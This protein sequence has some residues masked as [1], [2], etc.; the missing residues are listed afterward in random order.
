MSFQSLKLL[1]ENLFPGSPQESPGRS[2]EPTWPLE[3]VM[4]EK[5]RKPK[6]L[7]YQFKR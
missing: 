3:I 2:R 7:I 1:E 5:R 4:V 6:E